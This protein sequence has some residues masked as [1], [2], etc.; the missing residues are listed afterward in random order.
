[1]ELIVKQGASVL[2]FVDGLWDVWISSIGR[3]FSLKEST[4]KHG[5][6]HSGSLL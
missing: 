5:Q 1:M 2:P 6:I 3:D 4:I